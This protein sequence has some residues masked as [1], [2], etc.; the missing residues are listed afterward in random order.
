SL[1]KVFWNEFEGCASTDG[2]V[3]SYASRKSKIHGRS[4]PTHDLDRDK[5]V[6]E[7]GG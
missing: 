3:V 7:G 4:Y 1:L 5:S 2:Q 6:A